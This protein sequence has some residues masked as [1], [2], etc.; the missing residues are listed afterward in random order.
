[1]LREWFLRVFPASTAGQGKVFF[2]GLQ[3]LVFGGVIVF[4]LKRFS[5]KQESFFKVREA[6]R[7]QSPSQKRSG[8]L[9]LADAKILPRKSSQTSRPLLLSGIRID[10]PPHEILGISEH[11]TLEEIQGAYRELMKQYHPD[12]VGRPGSR[13]WQDAQK[14]AEAINRARKELLSHHSQS[15]KRSGR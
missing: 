13:E 6:D 3:A 7:P 12:R 4:F 14:I 2:I 5:G 1:M 15:P 11:A 8:E 9:G 10:C